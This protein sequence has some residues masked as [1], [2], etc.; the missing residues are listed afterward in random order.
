VRQVKRKAAALGLVVVE[1][2]AE[3][4]PS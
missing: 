4:H 3:A 2:D 1:R